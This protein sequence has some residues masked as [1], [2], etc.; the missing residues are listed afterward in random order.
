MLKDRFSLKEMI[1]ISLLA[2]TATVSKVPIRA[3]SI[4]LTSSVGLPAGIV[5]GVF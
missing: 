3:L 1:Y 5:G 4:F 2:T